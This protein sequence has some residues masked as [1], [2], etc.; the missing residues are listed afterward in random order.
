MILA[1]YEKT[2]ESITTFLEDNILWG[3]TNEIFMGFATD[4]MLDAEESL[5]ADLAECF[6]AKKD[7]IRIEKGLIS[8]VK[9]LENGNDSLG[10]YNGLEK[11]F[12]NP[13]TS[14]PLCVI[15]SDWEHL[16]EQSIV[17][18]KIKKDAMAEANG[19]GVEFPGNTLFSIEL[20]NEISS[21]LERIDRVF[22]MILEKKDRI[23]ILIYLK[24]NIL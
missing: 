5:M 16:I 17:Y 24:N 15:Y 20:E 14:R 3:R 23:H 12:F 10:F 4:E 18:D 9:E 8:L 22:N 19:I 1:N 6:L 21:Y 7:V 2:V 13:F 11:M